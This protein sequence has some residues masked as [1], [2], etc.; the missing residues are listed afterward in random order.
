MC[1]TWTASVHTWSV[2]TTHILAKELHTPK[3]PLTEWPW[4]A[5]CEWSMSI[6]TSPHFSHPYSCLQTQRQRITVIITVKVITM[7]VKAVVRTMNH[8]VIVKLDI[9]EQLI[10]SGLCSVT[11]SNVDM[12]SHQANMYYY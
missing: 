3:A 7:I 2:Q 6:L 1:L 11:F 10:L 12:D 9:H 4:M 5:S 8:V